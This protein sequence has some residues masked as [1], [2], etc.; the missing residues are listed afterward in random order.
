MDKCRRNRIHQLVSGLNR[1]RHTQARKI[2]ILCQDI[3][4]AHDNFVRYLSS[5]RFAMN[6]YESIIGIDN[7]E[8]I[9]E[10]AG[11]IICSDLGDLNLNIILRSPEQLVSHHSASSSTDIDNQ[12]L[13]GCITDK[14]IKDV[15]QSNRIC[16][17]DDMLGMG[18]LASPVIL[19]KISIAAIPLSRVGPAVG[20]MML[21][22]SSQ[23]P[24]RR[25]ELTRIASI[26][27]GFG[28]AIT[29]CGNKMPASNLG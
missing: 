11:E 10:I 26:T 14:L 1:T 12:E 22:R 15:C 25:Q 6:F 4:P 7:L 21:Y 9:L 16:T 17:L 20:I 2:D 19:K 29:S 23:N 5:F 8:G 24:L 3:I 27:A 13:I 18:F 28:K